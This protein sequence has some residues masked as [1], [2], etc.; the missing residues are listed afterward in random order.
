M[1][2]LL[3]VAALWGTL[4][5]AAFA[6]ELEEGAEVPDL[7]A[8]IQSGKTLN[9]KE[10]ASK[11]YALIYF[12]PKADTAG[13]TAQACSL[14]DAY[15]E[16]TA[17]GVKVIGVSTDTVAAQAA[18]K[19]KYSLPFDLVA[20]PE[21]KVI[22]AFGVPYM[23]IKNFAKR[24]AYLFKD[25]KLIWRSLSASTKTQADD[26]LKVLAEYEGK[27]QEQSRQPQEQASQQSQP[28]PS[29]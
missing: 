23:P 5:M 16:L 15:E 19:E 20:D 24:Q 18:F 7:T 27:Q 2:R 14:R 28:E 8:T 6:D 12:Y 9:L 22:E 1:R 13:C 25:G 10:V 11:G 29:K 17:K 4:G 3:V 21:G 26:V